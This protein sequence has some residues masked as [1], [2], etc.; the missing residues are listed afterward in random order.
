MEGT[1]HWIEALL[2][3]WPIRPKEGWPMEDYLINKMG[4]KGGW[5][6]VVK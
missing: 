3:L 1:F 6:L 2:G 4:G 5:F